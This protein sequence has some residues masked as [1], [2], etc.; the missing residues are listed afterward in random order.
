MTDAEALRAIRNLLDLFPAE[1][2]DAVVDALRT[3]LDQTFCAACK[4]KIGEDG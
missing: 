2:P 4:R 3:R 1:A